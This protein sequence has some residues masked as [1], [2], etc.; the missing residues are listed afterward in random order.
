MFIQDVSNNNSIN[1][2]INAIR[3]FI[4]NTSSRAIFRILKKFNFYIF[5]F[6]R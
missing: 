5:S 3:M 4:I 6:S 1:Q 2:L